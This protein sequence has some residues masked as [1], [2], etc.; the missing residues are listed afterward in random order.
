MA[1]DRTVRMLRMA[2][3]RTVE[4][5]STKMREMMMIFGILIEVRCNQKKKRV[6][7]V[8]CRNRTQ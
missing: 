1:S 2:S 3:D 7:L 6:R 5:N 4:I 8:S